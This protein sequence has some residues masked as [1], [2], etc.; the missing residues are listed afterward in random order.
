MTIK[1]LK[2]RTGLYQDQEKFQNLRSDQDREKFPHLGPDQNQQ[3]FENLGPI[4]TGQSP[5]PWVHLT[6]S[7]PADSEYLLNYFFTT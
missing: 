1:K 3:N 5:D 6:C 7:R 4:R 2:I